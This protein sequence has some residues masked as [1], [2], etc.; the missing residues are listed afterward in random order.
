MKPVSLTLQN[1]GPFCH[2]QTVDFTKFYEESLF[3]I[4]GDTGAGKTTIFDAITYALY[5]D[6]SGTR[7]KTEE[8]R[9]AFAEEG[10][11]CSVTLTFTVRDRTYTIYRAPSYTKPGRATPVPTKVQLTTPEGICTSVN[12]VQATVRSLLGMDIDQFRKTVM[13]AQGEFCALL[14]AKSKDKQEIFRRIF[15]TYLYQRISE[16]IKEEY[17]AQKSD[18]AL[19]YERIRNSCAQLADVRDEQ[20]Q[21]LLIQDFLQ[22]KKISDCLQRVVAEKSEM[23]A[24]QEEETETLKREKEK[25]DPEKAQKHN[26]LLARLETV[27]QMRH[28]CD[29][30]QEEMT[31]KREEL[32][33]GRKSAT[34]Y[35]E[36]KHLQERKQEAQRQEKSLDAKKA[37]AEAA[38]NDFET[39]VKDHDKADQAIKNAQAMKEE[40]T[41]LETVEEKILET[42][43]IRRRLGNLRNEVQEDRKK[44]KIF[45]EIEQILTLKEELKC[46]LELQEL[47]QKAGAVEESLNEE[48][49]NFLHKKEQYLTALAAFLDSS[50]G[51]LAKDLKEGQPCP[52]CGSKDH[53]MK[54]VLKADSVTQQEVNLAKDAMENS[55]EKRMQLDMSLKELRRKI[56][57][58][59]EMSTDTEEMK[60]ALFLMQKDI[61]SAFP[62]I[63]DVDSL[64]A[65]ITKNRE[66]LIA[67]QNSISE[68]ESTLKR[69][70]LP[71]E[72]NT[73]E[74]LEQKRR[75]LT[76]KIQAETQTAQQIADKISSADKTLK[77]KDAERTLLETTL[78][79]MK[80]NVRSAESNFREERSRSGFATEEELFDSVRGEEEL[81]SLEKEIKDFEA[82]VI[83]LTTE[84]KELSV[85]IGNRPAVD[86]EALNRRLGEIQEQLEARQK[87]QRE[88]Q[89]TVLLAE[90]SRVQLCKLADE[91]K[92]REQ[93]LS[94][95]KELYEASSGN[96]GKRIAFER[97]VLG[98][99]FDDILEASNER[100]F[101]MTSQRFTMRRK[102]EKSAGNISDGLEIEVLDSYTGTARSISSLSG[103]ESFKAALA[104]ALG[105]GDVVQSQ[106]GGISIETMFIDEG[107]GTLDADSLQ[108]AIQC[109]MD[110]NRST[111]R[112]IGIISHVSELKERIPAK[113]AI[114]VSPCGS[115]IHS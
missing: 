65:E 45:A 48:T 6:A 3:L 37:E 4:T 50:A 80:E 40:L 10:D 67:A 97:Y 24:A 77:S 61:P 92:G 115:I 28:A 14:Q 9:S 79:E 100:F 12:D 2:T 86:L 46:R 93:T 58:F 57:D 102:E 30:R 11:V 35:A 94:D 89:N 88:L 62:K 87:S 68:L 25:N 75:E 34:L 84:E 42:E 18:Y 27:R 36:Y 1:F 49:T 72:L 43:E 76:K 90:K 99:Y 44:L 63:T 22:P 19:Y 95:L 83:R 41:R 78:R 54:A 85:Q 13:L 110:L 98:A 17:D 39:A 106:S 107:F 55:A 81:S 38:R 111:S 29:E 7:R 113:I 114:E 31:Q 26:Q 69:T 52:V 5:G 56:A 51:L 32:M 70:A 8:L 91:E 64:N 103:G 104:L 59:G 82:S 20:L 66:S 96:K 60:S 101:A 15:D 109:L 108:S 74:L 16:K 21:E 73:K 47:L 105:M 23:L 53:P 33:K 71:S 112:M